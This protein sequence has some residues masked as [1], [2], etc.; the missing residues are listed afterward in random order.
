MDIPV[1]SDAVPIMEKLRKPF[2]KLQPPRW[3]KLVRKRKDKLAGYDRAGVPFGVFGSV[4]KF[5][6][7]SGPA[8]NACTLDVRAPGIVMY[9]AGSLVM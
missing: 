6:A 8:A 1:C 4:P 7:R 9:P 2:D 5:A 3:R